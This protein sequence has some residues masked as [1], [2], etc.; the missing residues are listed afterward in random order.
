MATPL[1]NTSPDSLVP[2]GYVVGSGGAVAFACFGKV[3]NSRAKAVFKLSI[4]AK[5]GAEIDAWLLSVRVV[6][7]WMAIANS[8]RLVGGLVVKLG[9]EL[10]R[11]CN[12]SKSEYCPV[13]I[14]GFDDRGAFLMLTSGGGVEV[15]RAVSA[16]VR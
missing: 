6:R 3:A 13:V 8:W 1:S 9:S 12:F 14:G 11:R 7:D 10:Y 2:S 16:V 4:A 15:N 5:S